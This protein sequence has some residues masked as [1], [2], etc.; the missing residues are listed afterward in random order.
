MVMHCNNPRSHESYHEDFD[1][2]PNGA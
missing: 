2:P 1:D